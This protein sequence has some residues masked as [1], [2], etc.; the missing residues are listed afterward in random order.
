MSNLYFKVYF[1]KCSYFRNIQ[2]T[3]QQYN[4]LQGH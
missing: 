3:T 4:L 2:L 1:N